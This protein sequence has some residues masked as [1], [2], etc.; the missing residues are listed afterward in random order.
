MQV[1]E[2]QYAPNG[3]I[4]IAYKVFGAGE[5]DLLFSGGST[6]NIETVW[7]LPEAVRFLG[8][9]GRFARVV[10]FDRR[11][12]GISDPIREDL[13][14]EAH[15]ADALAVMGAVGMDRAVLFGATDCARAFATLAASHPERVSGLI[16][17]A[18]SPGLTADVPAEL[19]ADVARAIADPNYPAGLIDVLAPEWA[20]DPERRDRFATY[21]RTSAT[22]RQAERVF[23]MSASTDV[24]EVLPLVQAPTLVLGPK[25]ALIPP[26]ES[27]RRFAGLIPGAEFR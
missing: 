16:A 10:F 18:A 6:S 12:T 7:S 4:K 27:V 15:V 26:V 14:L 9:L 3:E 1:P 11:D 24:S 22:P 8:R 2:T 23:R 20:D 5:Y 17:L 21:A 13:A 19:A 25:R